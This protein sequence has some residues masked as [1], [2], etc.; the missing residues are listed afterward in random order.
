MAHAAVRGPFWSWRLPL[1]QAF[2]SRWMFR[3]RSGGLLWRQSTFLQGMG[4]AE[5]GGYLPGGAESM[6]L[7]RAR[8]HTG[9]REGPPGERARNGQQSQAKSRGGDQR[10]DST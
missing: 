1:A 5:G 7:P 8:Q 4:T 9:L 6:Q 2:P 3:T 10:E